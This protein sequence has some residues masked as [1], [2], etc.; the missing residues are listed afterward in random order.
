VVKNAGMQLRY[1]PAVV[2]FLCEFR[3][4]FDSDST[5]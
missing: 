1:I 2:F 5:D 4:C 3:R